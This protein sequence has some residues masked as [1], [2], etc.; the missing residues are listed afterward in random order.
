[1]TKPFIAVVAASAMLIATPV[2]AAP[3]QGPYSGASEE[4][5][6]AAVAL[7]EAGV[8]TVAGVVA[9]PLMLGAGGSIAVGSAAESLGELSQDV[10]GE[11]SDAGEASADVATSPLSV[12]DDVV[13]KPQ[14]A[15]AVPYRAN[16]AV[17]PQ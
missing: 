9:V 15:P 1:M 3:A 10:G 16:P 11:F 17:K 14:S 12:T 6:E 2:L 13:L 7:A 5:A 4:S 8:K